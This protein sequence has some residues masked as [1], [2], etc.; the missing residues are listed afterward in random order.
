ML[1][2]HWLSTAII[3]SCLLLFCQFS[4]TIADSSL[5]HT[6]FSTEFSVGGLLNFLT[7]INL[8][9]YLSTAFSIAFLLLA[10]V[11]CIFDLDVL[12]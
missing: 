1:P 4:T 2:F 11:E 10:I 9:L 7:N 6:Y 12:I 3:G 5:L 8:H